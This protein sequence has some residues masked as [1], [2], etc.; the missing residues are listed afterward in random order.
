MLV[1]F[2]LFCVLGFVNNKGADQTV[3]SGQ[4]LCYSLFEKENVCCQKCIS[5]LF[6]ILT[7]CWWLLRVVSP[8]NN[9]FRLRTQKEDNEMM[10]TK[11]RVS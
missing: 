9:V 3:Q 7:L 10:N 6:E 4:C 8:Y 11:V 1:N 5:E 2:S